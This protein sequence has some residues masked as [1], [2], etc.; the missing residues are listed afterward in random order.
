MII[1]K[2]FFEA[3]RYLENK[4]RYYESS[5]ISNLRPYLKRQRKGL[6]NTTKSLRDASFA[7]YYEMSENKKVP[8]RIE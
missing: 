5:R 4:F 2:I 8:H 1:F 3:M 6:R 7:V